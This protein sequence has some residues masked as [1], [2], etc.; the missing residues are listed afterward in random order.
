MCNMLCV[1]VAGDAVECF[2]YIICCVFVFYVLCV[3][4]C[5]LVEIERFCVLCF[6]FCGFI[7]FTTCLCFML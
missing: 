2:I 7:L 5:V 6:M 3:M 1:L 4:F